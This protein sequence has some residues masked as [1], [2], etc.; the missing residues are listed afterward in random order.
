VAEKKGDEVLS[1]VSSQSLIMYIA[2]TDGIPG[3]EKG[4]SLGQ[5]VYPAL[6]SSCL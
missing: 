4:K 5:T 2:S 1:V 3:G 6:L